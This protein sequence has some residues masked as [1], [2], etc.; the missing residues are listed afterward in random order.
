MP[1]DP[2]INCECHIPYVLEHKSFLD[3]HDS[4]DDTL[5]KMGSNSNSGG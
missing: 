5:L 1:L 3:V 4:A 2:C